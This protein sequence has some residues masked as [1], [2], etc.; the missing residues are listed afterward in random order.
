[1]SN[2]IRIEEDL[3]GKRE[4]PAEAYYGI[5]TLRA[6]ENFYISD[7]TINDVPEFIRGMVLVKKAAALANKELHTIP[8]KIA[9]IIVKACDEVLNTGKCLD[10][11]PVD[12]F[13]GGAGTSLN[14]NTNEVLANIGLELM[15]HPKGEY[16]YLNPNDHLNRSQSTND[17]YPTGF[18]I[19]VYNSIMKL[20][21]SIEL[22]Q[23]GFDK[24]SVEFADIL[25][26][27]RTQLQ[28]AVPMTLGQ[29]FRAFSVLLK[30]EI[31]NITRTAELLLEVNLGATAIG[32]GL[33]TAPGYQTLVVEKLAEVTG[34]PCLPAEDLIE[35]TSDCG[36]YVMVHSAL[37]R[38][39]VKM[40][41]ICNDLRL[42][43]SGPRTGLNEIN[44][45]ELQAGSSIMPA[46]VNPVVPEVVNQVC[47]KVIGNDICVTMASEAGQL[48]LNVMEPAIGQAM[49]ESISILSNACRNLVEKCVNGITA[50]KEV[51]ESFVFNSIGIV[52]YLNPFIGHHNGDIVGKICAETGK[53]VREV[54]LERGLLTEA[55]LDDIFSVENLKHPTYKA[56]RF[57]D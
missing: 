43:S 57:D 20:I 56:K 4:V 19:A 48:Q 49:F 24:K 44:L 21:T 51:C 28:D 27:G 18:R 10:Q 22:L 52:T 5:H 37:K 25:K 32:T 34:L 12:V 36:A 11:F 1:M 55:Q 30:E 2:N 15:G 29:E 40:S 14:M 16:E 6:I 23:V 46:K 39:A 47:F 53:S 45:P 35:A 41:K 9:D 26:M 3:L 42:L 31:K 13:Q 50:N 33:N 17:A 7:R 54:V 38:L 8:G